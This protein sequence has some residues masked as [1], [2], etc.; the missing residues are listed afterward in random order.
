DGEVPARAAL[1]AMFARARVARER[2][3]ALRFLALD[4]ERDL[5][6]LCNPSIPE[7]RVTDA[8]QTAQQLLAAL[9]SLTR[10]LGAL[11]TA[12]EAPGCFPKEQAP[13]GLRTIAAL[14][15]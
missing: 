2:L 8:N 1:D 5:V 9:E 14:L 3:A 10:D 13:G 12:L 4:N 7:R 6:R 15:A 11:S